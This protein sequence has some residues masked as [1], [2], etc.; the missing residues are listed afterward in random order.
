MAITSLNRRQ[1]AAL[2]L[3]SVL[4]AV[5]LG[6]ARLYADGFFTGLFGDRPVF[7]VSILALLGIFAG[8]FL[9]VRRHGHQ[10]FLVLWCRRF[11]HWNREEGRRN[12]W[13]RDIIV[14]ATNGF[15]LPVTISD[16][17]V[18]STGSISDNLE[19]LLVL[20]LLLPV[21]AVILW[22]VFQVPEGM[23]DNLLG[24]VVIMALFAAGWF[25]IILATEWFTSSF[26][27]YR[28]DPDRLRRKLRDIA[29]RHYHHGDS[30]VIRCTDEDWQACVEAVLHEST[31]AIVDLSDATENLTWEIRR[32]LDL[33]GPARV[34]FI[35]ES[36]S[37][38]V[39]SLVHKPSPEET[40][41]SA[42]GNCTFLSYSRQR[43][44][45]ERALYHERDNHHE[46][47]ANGPLAKALADSIRQW[48]QYAVQEKE[49]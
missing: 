39:P 6:V 17:S 40:G 33:L 14:H 35:A 23:L 13:L 3:A 47:S 22:I 42:T 29:D 41:V 32:S 37:L 5:F 18:T 28:D 21:T 30:F 24:F 31:L 15:A 38:D 45:E 48:M 46:P 43:A 8:L 12:A 10:G 34:L 4:L 1:F 16:R 2:A 20:L 49:A 25:F 26:A 27:T 11:G 9:A 44:Q 7:G 36:D 19:P